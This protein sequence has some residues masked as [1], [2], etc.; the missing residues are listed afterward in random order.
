MSTTP[1][2]GFRNWLLVWKV[3]RLG[4]D[5][6]EVISTVYELAALGVTVISDECV[7]LE[8]TNPFAWP[9][10]IQYKALKVIRGLD[11]TEVIFPNGTSV[12]VTDPAAVMV[13]AN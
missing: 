13:S 5:M 6:R 7:R 8:G 9:V 2:I 1:V 12:S 10:T 11:R 3:S 4:R